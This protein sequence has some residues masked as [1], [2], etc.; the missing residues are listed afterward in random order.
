MF[1]TLKR[2]LDE[3]RTPL[4]LRYHVVLE[5]PV[6]VDAPFFIEHDFVAPAAQWE[7]VCALRGIGT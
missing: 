2:P 4:G 6:T 3:V 7:L 5:R 1:G